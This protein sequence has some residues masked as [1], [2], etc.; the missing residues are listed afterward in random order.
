[1]ISRCTA[2]APLKQSGVAADDQSC[3]PKRI[4]L[5][6][7]NPAI[8]KLVGAVLRS[9]GYDVLSAG[10]GLEALGILQTNSSIGLVLSDVVMGE[11]TGL[12]L[13]EKLKAS[14]PELKCILMSSYDVGSI[15]AELGA[16]FLAK[17][18]LPNDLL[19]KVR[20]V[21]ATAI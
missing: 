17:P 3:T 9:G 18:F 5:V 4:L 14:R 16:Y 21:L 19:G 8:R 7:D 10:D 6:D 13:C 20:E 12:Q 11:M 15:A 2:P 1:M